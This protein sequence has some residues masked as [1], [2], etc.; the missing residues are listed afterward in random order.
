M[1][2][3]KWTACFDHYSFHGIAQPEFLDHPFYLFRP[4]PQFFRR[5]IQTHIRTGGVYAS[6]R[7]CRSGSENFSLVLGEGARRIGPLERDERIVNA[8]DGLGVM[9]EGDNGVRVSGNLRDQSDVYP[10]PSA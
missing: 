4:D 2:P 5:F 9:A 8:S 6:R 10:L 3:R 7:I 1:S